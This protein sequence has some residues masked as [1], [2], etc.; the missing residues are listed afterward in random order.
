MPI[1]LQNRAR[2]HKQRGARLDALANRELY[3]CHRA[4]LSNCLQRVARCLGAR[5]WQGLGQTSGAGHEAQQSEY[6]PPSA[7]S[8]FAL[9]RLFDPLQ[10]VPTYHDRLLLAVKENIVDI[11]D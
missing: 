3:R 1:M 5:R 7:C 10:V 11:L 9:P 2:P 6:G 4:A 8:G